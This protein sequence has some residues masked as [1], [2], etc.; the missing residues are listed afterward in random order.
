M[1]QERIY[2]I[3]E[4]MISL[5][6]AV[7]QIEKA[8]ELREEGFSQQET[9]GKL[10]LDRSFISRLESIGEIRKGSRV[11]VVGFPIANR[12]ELAAVCRRYGLDFFLLLNNRERWDLVRDSQALDFFNKILE[13]VTKLRQFDTLILV[14]SEKWFHL[15]EALLDIQIV[16]LTLGPTPIETDRIVEAERLKN[17]LDSVIRA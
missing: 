17:A 9:A 12:D 8:L 15:A 1:P 11:A 2:R 14:T 6:R 13:L 3:G 16:Y 10:Q 7:H 5:D 4:K